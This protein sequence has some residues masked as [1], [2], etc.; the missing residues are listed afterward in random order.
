MFVFNKMWR[1]TGSAKRDLDFNGKLK[2]QS[3]GLAL[4]AGVVFQNLDCG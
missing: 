2:D 4:R 3:Q 1:G